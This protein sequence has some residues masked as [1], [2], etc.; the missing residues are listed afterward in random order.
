MNAVALRIQNGI[1]YVTELRSKVKRGTFTKI[2]LF[3]ILATIGYEFV[4][5]LFRMLTLS[6]MS[7][8]DIIDPAVIWIPT[9]LSF[10]NLRIAFEVMNTPTALFNS[11]WFSSMLAA[12]QTIV[13]A[14]TG[15]ALARF[16]FK[17]KK[18]WLFMLI[19]TFVLPIPLLSVP[20]NMMFLELHRLTGLRFIGTITPQSMLAFFGQG[21]YS[22]ILVLIFYNFMQLIPRSLDEAAEI[23]GANK[24]QVF[25]HIGIRISISTLLVVFLLS[26][27]WNWN[28][29]FM[30]TMF[31]RGGIELLP[32]NLV[33]FESLFAPIGPLIDT[34]GGAMAMV[35]EAYIMAGTLI[36][37]L[38]LVILYFFVQQ[39]FIKGIESTGITGE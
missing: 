3:I 39:R 36:S 19:V 28:E 26:V 24:M 32:G 8:T 15:Y 25:Y 5:P 9:S 10:S 35:N 22:T 27:V 21:V 33:H 11:I 2:V 30:T 31:L 7:R 18:F 1:D 12:F 17:Y 23:D 6:L 4:F 20:R 37:M 38:P 14:L 16:D 29:T 13:A 34:P